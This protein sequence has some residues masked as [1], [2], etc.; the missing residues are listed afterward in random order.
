MAENLHII[1]FE[2]GYKVPENLKHYYIVC[3]AREKMNILRG[4][5]SALKPKKAMVFIN[6]EY[7]IERA[8]QKL[9]YHHYHAAYIHGGSKKEQRQKAIADFRN[10]KLPILIATD[11]ASRGLHFRNV[12]L[13]VHYTIP[14]DAKDYLHRAGRCAREGRTGVNISIV[15]QKEVKRVRQFGRALSLNMQEKALK[16]GKLV[17]VKDKRK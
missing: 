5:I 8:A 17:D 11:L 15:T 13:I 1:R 3:D 4:V 9:R 14:E 10:G 7:E 6:R 2:E 16:D 12:S